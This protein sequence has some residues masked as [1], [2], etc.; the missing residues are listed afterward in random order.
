MTGNPVKNGRTREK[1]CS[2]H[3]IIIQQ[4]IVNRD[5]FVEK[6]NRGQRVSIYDCLTIALEKAMLKSKMNGC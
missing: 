3:N 1:D 4:N 6:I 2:L 5:T